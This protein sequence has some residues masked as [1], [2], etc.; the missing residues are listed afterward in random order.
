MAFRLFLERGYKGTSMDAIAQAADVTKPVIYAC[1]ASKA[2]LFG[3]LLDRE[4]QRVFAQFGAALAT[5]AGLE[6]REAMLTAGFTAMLR[7]VSE[8]PETY[9]VALRGGNDANALID[10]RIRRGREQFV[11]QLTEAARGWLAGRTPAR[12]LDG[13]AQFVGHT[14]AGI[15]DAGL[16]MM[17]ASPDRWTPETLGHALGR[18]TTAGFTTFSE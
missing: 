8:T 18:F 12:R 11:A 7:A 10:A 17:L 2:E 6:D 14:L 5:S 9:R 16:R 4:E 15:G 1:F 3:A 13:S